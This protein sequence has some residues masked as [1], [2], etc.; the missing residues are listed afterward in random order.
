[1]TQHKAHVRVCFL[2]PLH[3]G[4]QQIPADA[5]E[6]TDADETVLEPHGFLALSLQR[7]LRLKNGLNIRVEFLPVLGE[8]YAVLPP[9]QQRDPGF[10]LQCPDI[11]AHGALGI[12]Q[13]LRRMGKAP[14]LHHPAEDAIAG[15]HVSSPSIIRFA[16]A[17][18]INIRFTNFKLC[19]NLIKIKETKES[20]PWTLQRI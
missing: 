5:G 15:Y 20:F 2:K 7:L 11:L 19:D 4:R 1:M 9:G 18:I 6:G 10:L 12:A 13:I 3:H 8:L 17:S 16:Y 14:L